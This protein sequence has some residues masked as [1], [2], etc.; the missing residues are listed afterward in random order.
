M[1]AW[2]TTRE[3]VKAAADI[4]ESARKN[5][6]VDRAIESASRAVEGLLR[7]RFYPWTGTRYFDQPGL[8]ASSLEVDLAE[9][10]LISTTAVTS[11]GIAVTSGDY[12]LEPVNEGPPFDTV[13]IDQASG[14]VFDGGDTYQRNL[15]IT[16]VWGWDLT[17]APAGAL[18]EALDGSEVGVDVTGATAAAVGVGSIVFCESEWMTVTGRQMLDTTVNTGGALAASTNDVTVAVADGTL[19][20]VDEVLL[21][22]AERLLV[23]DIAGNNLVVKRAHD[24]TVLASHLTG[25]DIYASRRLTV[26]RGA[27]GTTAAT[28]ADT[29]ALTVW[30]P[31]GLIAELCVALSLTTLAQR[32]GSYVR[33]T[34]SNES[35]RNAA[36]RNVSEIQQDAVNLYGRVRVGAV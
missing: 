4:K 12:F 33:V 23:V 2:Y 5:D 6:Q 21:V 34:G 22:D 35:E 17:A 16:G 27:L 24:G 20:A 3:V 30:Q 36:H 25:A 32:Q 18:A 8:Y 31:P 10:G 15:A 14:V 28:H 7:R 11:G 1:G 19:F 26:T 9:H 29:T 13:R